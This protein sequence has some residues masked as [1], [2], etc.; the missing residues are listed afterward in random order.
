MGLGASYTAL[1][2]Q[3]NKQEAL[4]VL[5]FFFLLQADLP[6]VSKEQLRR[7]RGKGKKKD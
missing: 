2:L 3:S 4:V 6:L 1:G 5:S 7:V